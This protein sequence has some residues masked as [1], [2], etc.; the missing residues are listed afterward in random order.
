M[1]ISISEQLGL[2]FSAH[3]DRHLVVVWLKIRLK[4]IAVAPSWAVIIHSKNCIVRVTYTSQ[5]HGNFCVCVF[6]ALSCLPEASS[7]QG[8]LACPHRVHTAGSLQGHIEA[9]IVRTTKNKA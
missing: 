8:G 7:Q 9:P 2:Y 5:R 6:S 1:P 3:L 4:R